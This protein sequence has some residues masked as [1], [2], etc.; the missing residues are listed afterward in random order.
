MRQEEQSSASAPGS[1]SDPGGIQVLVLSP[2]RR[3]YYKQ[4]QDSAHGIWEACPLFMPPHVAFCSGPV[5]LDPI[6]SDPFFP[7]PLPDS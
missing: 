4:R 3:A 6:L 2:N 1:S 7:P 5:L